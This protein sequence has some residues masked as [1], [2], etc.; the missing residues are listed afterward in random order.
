MVCLVASFINGLPPVFDFHQHPVLSNSPVRP[1][2]ELLRATT[3]G[4]LVHSTI[5]G[6]VGAVW[7]KRRGDVSIFLPFFWMRCRAVFFVL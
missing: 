5:S 4:P 2:E 6:W 3:V 1:R 7:P